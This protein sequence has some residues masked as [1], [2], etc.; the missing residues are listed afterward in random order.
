MI[1]IVLCI[2]DTL[3][4]PKILYKIPKSTINPHVEFIPNLMD[5]END[6]FFIH[7]FKDLKT[8]N[9]QFKVFNPSTRG[10]NNML[11]LSVYSHD[12]Q[13]PIDLSSFKEIIIYFAE[14][15]KK[16]F[17]FENITKDEET[18][19]ALKKVLYD[20][21]KALAK[22]RVFFEQNYSKKVY[23]ELSSNGKRALLN[24]L[25]ANFPDPENKVWV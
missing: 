20:F 23:Y 8:A 2:F 21:H 5:L 22:E 25:N 15:L 13:C 9:Y 7:E 3:I 18:F 12:E 16:N 1:G 10:M 24:R 11:M 14:K 19:N 17:I 6:D 4:G